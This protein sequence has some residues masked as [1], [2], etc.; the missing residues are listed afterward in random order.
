VS[1]S[2]PTPEVSSY[3]TALR[4]LRAGRRIPALLIVSQ[5]LDS[6][7]GRPLARQLLA[8]MYPE[9]RTRSTAED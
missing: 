6:A 5:L 2:T 1:K 7:A 3:L 4:L 8:E 9:V